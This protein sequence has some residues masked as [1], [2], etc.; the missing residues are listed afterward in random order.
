MAPAAES[1][2]TARSAC[3]G[4]EETEAVGDIEPFTQ[5]VWER[6]KDGKL[7]PEM[8]RYRE[9]VE[10]RVH[11]Y[12]MLESEGTLYELE[13]TAPGDKPLHPHSARGR[14]EISAGFSPAEMPDAPSPEVS[15]VFLFSQALYTL[16]ISK[17]P[18]SKHRIKKGLRLW[19]QA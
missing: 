4:E 14:S 6:G 10:A 5:T 18:K 8:R 13:K 17:Q 15:F 11:G 1:I 3:Y 9:G 19:A 7:T 16:L 2:L 12:L